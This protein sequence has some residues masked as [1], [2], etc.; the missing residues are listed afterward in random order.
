MGKL[1]NF[2]ARSTADRLP[3]LQRAVVCTHWNTSLQVVNA[4]AAGGNQIIFPAG[5]LQPP[6]F[7]ERAGD[8]MVAGNPIIVW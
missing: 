5:I 1:L 3:A 2:N 6:F 4:F 8:A 7:D